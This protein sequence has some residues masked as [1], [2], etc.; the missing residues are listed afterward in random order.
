MGNSVLNSVSLS[1]A[2]IFLDFFFLRKPLFKI[3]KMKKKLLLSLPYFSQNEK[4][5]FQINTEKNGPIAGP[6][7]E[8]CPRQ[9]TVYPDAEHLMAASV[10]TSSMKNVL[11]CN[12]HLLLLICTGKMIISVR[13]N[14]LRYFWMV[15]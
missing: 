9:C 15:D 4:K 5:F 8:S 13:K 6:E 12:N 1:T 3:S 10:T 14:N 2:L 11:L 7:M